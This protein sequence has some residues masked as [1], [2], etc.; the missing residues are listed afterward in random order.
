[1]IGWPTMY[2]VWSAV[3]VCVN[4]GLPAAVIV[5]VEAFPPPHCVV[6]PVVVGVTVA[7]FVTAP[8]AVTTPVT[9]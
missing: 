6:Q 8:A 1:V 7:V 2:D 9:V 5:E 3:L 4:T